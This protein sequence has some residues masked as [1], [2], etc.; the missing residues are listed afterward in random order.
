[1]HLKR[2]K[3]PK[4]W[5]I[6]RK[7]T[8]YIVRPDS[9]LGKGLPI[10]IILREILKIVQNR[11]EAK[12]AIHFRNILI[13][14][15]P[16]IDEKQS[17]SLFDTITMIPSKKYFRLELSEKGKFQVKEISEADALRKIAKIISKKILKGKKTQLNLSDGQNFLSNLTC[18]I[19]DSVLI[20]FKDKKIEKCLPLREKANIM[21]FDGKHAGSI[22]TVVKID[23]KNK[24]AEV[25]LEEKPAN[26]LIKQL[27]VT[28]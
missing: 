18:N 20:S 21:I 13:N 15:K 12:K 28:G 10:L 19:N 24:M 27:M 8:V 17:A 9:N 23:N 14:N 16:V 2:Q 6:P 26:I 5:P 4:K 7:E 3:S 22:G 1:M 11:K 25:N